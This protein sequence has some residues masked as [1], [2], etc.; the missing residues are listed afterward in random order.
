MYRWNKLFTWIISVLKFVFQSFFKKKINH[1]V[2]SGK[3]QSAQMI[4]HPLAY[5]VRLEGA[6]QPERQWPISVRIV[7][8]GH[9]SS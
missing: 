2:F 8:K 7:A 4:F 6:T 9:V 3:I 1:K 5:I